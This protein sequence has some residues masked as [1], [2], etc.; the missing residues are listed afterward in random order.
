MGRTASRKDGESVLE[1]ADGR[2]HGQDWLDARMHASQVYERLRKRILPLVGAPVTWPVTW[3]VPIPFYADPD[4][5]QEAWFEE[6]LL[7]L[8]RVHHP[9][10][11]IERSDPSSRNWWLHLNMETTK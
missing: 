9:Q 2:E 4:E 10:A 11:T 8:I 1:K 5:G 6:R 3:V 7:D